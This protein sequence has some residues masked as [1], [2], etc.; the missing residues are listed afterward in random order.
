MGFPSGYH[1]HVKA[2]EHELRLDARLPVKT[3]QLER[4]LPE[5]EKFL[6]PQVNFRT[7]E[8]FSPRHLFQTHT[9][10]ALIGSCR[11]ARTS[12][13]PRTNNDRTVRQCAFSRLRADSSGWRSD[14]CGCNDDGRAWRTV[15][16]V[17]SIHR[18]ACSSAGLVNDGAFYSQ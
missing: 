7:Q 9:C 17:W 2:L 14:S 4:L 5:R 15:H 11:R 13:D 12:D 18:S 8:G 16:S 6:T 3:V 10:N 1:V